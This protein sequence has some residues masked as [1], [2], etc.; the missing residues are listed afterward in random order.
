MAQL[1]ASELL[2]FRLVLSCGYMLVPEWEVKRYETQGLLA[3]KL[4]T[5]RL[6]RWPT[7]EVCP[8]QPLSEMESKLLSAVNE[9]LS[10]DR[11]NVFAAENGIADVALAMDNLT[12]RGL[13]R[14]VTNGDDS[15]YEFV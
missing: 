10:G 12:E 3:K 11:Y 13:V 2:L 15:Y 5:V 7:Y 6:I 14:F 1:S 4:V 9:G 8:I